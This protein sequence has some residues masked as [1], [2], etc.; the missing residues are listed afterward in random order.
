MRRDALA[1]YRSTITQMWLRWIPVLT[2]LAALISIPGCFRYSTSGTSIPEN[3]NSIYIPFFADNSSG[4]VANLNELMYQALVDRFTRRSRLRLAPSPEQADIVLEGS[5]QNYSNR[6][7][8]IGSD[9]AA[10]LN[11]VEVT[12]RASFRYTSANEALWDRTFSGFSEYD[13][14]SDPLAGESTA[15]RLAV[16]Q[17]ATSLFQESIGKW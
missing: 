6:P 15:A 13:P 16:Q 12:I 10:K 9:Q 5:I 11:R 8:S 4:G 2:L 17:I 1:G 3:V 7:F 14:G